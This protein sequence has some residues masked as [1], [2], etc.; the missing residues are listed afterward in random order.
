M[1]KHIVNS[2]CFKCVSFQFLRARIG[3]EQTKSAHGKP[4][5]EKKKDNC[6]LSY[7]RVVM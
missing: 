2:A 5:N 1:F 6:R 4:L 3:F 7:N